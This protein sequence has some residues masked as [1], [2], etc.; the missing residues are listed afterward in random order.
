MIDVVCTHSPNLIVAHIVLVFV[1]NY[2]T[3]LKYGCLIKKSDHIR[4][5]YLIA[6]LLHFGM[7]NWVD[8]IA[9]V[10]KGAWFQV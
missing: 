2:H 7:H 5:T 1:L 4:P 6:H 10:K 3:P 9:V 8:C